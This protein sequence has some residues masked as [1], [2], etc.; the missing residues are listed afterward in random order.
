M[1]ECFSSPFLCFSE[2]QSIIKMNMRGLEGED[3]KRGLKELITSWEP[4]IKD[5]ESFEQAEE[6]LLHL[7]ENDENFHRHEFVKALKRK[8]D[9]TLSPL[10]NEEPERN[11]IAGHAD[12]HES[13]VNNIIDHILQ[14]REYMDLKS[15]LGKNVSEAVKN[16]VSNFNDEF[17]I[18]TGIDTEGPLKTPMSTDDEEGSVMLFNQD[19]LK[20]IAEN[21]SK[22][23][24][25]VTRR[26]Y[27][28]KL[29]QIISGEIVHNKHWQ[30]LRKNLL[31]VMADPDD[32]LS[33]LSLKFV[34]KSFTHTS[35]YTS[36]VFI[37]LIE[38]LCGQFRSMTM[39]PVNKG[40]DCSNK[41]MIKLIKG[42]RLMVEF[43]QEAPNY[44]VRY[45]LTYLEEIVHNSL[46]LLSLQIPA[47]SQNVKL[48]PLHFVAILD[49]GAQWFTKWMHANYC[50]RK[51]LEELKQY[52]AIVETSVRYCLDYSSSHRSPNDEVAQ[53]S[54]DLLK[55]SMTGNGKRLYYT[56]PELEYALFVHSLS[57]LGSLL[58]YEKGRSF[59]PIKLKDKQV[60]M[61]HLLKSLLGLVVDPEMVSADRKTGKVKFE[62]SSLV[63]EVLKSLCITEAMCSI[64]LC[65]DEMM[66][67]LLSPIVAFLEASPD[68]PVPSEKT[69]LHIADILCAVAST[70]IGR[71]FLL[72]G[73]GKSLLAKSKSSAAH[74]IADFTKRSLSNNL[75]KLLAPPSYLV[76]GAYLYV[77]RQL[78]NTPEGLYVLSQYELHSCIAQAWKQLQRE[79]SD[80]SLP[81]VKS[82][83][84]SVLDSWKETL[85]DNLLN[86]ASTAKGIVLLHQTG[87][88]NECVR[89]MY[90]R[91]EKKLQV[92]KCEKFGYGVMVTQV[93]A[94]SAGIQALQST[95]Y[96]KALLM[97]AWS[98]IE[99][100]P[101]DIPAF[102]PKSWPVDPI[103]RNSQKHFIRLVNILSA[104]P[105]VYEL[106]RGEPL[107]A[108]D[109]YS[110][111]D[112]P[113]SIMALI[114]RLIVVD[115]P[116][117]I[118]SLFNYEQ[119][120]TFGLRLLSVMVTCLDTFLLL[121]SQYKFQEF[122]LQEQE[123]NKLEGSDDFITDIL[124]VERNYILVKTY[125][126]G[127][128]TER[129]LP[130]RTLNDKHID[131][132]KPAHAQLPILFSSYPIPKE[133]QPNIQAK[134]STKQDNE[135]SKFLNASRQE[136]KPKVWME[137]CRELFYKLLINKP[138]Q[139]K[140][141]LLLQILEQTVEYQQQL[142]EEAIFPLFD[143]S[144]TDS[145]IKNFKLSPIQVLGVKMTIRYGMHLKV[146]TASS[147]S[148]ENLIQLMKQTGCFLKQQQRSLKSSLRFLEGSYP[149]F[150]WFTATVFLAFN[151]NR[152]KAWNFLYKL[153]SLGTSGYIW[154]VRLHSS[155]L[156]NNLLA[157]GIP[158]LFS[159]TAHNIELLLQSE[160]P[161]VTSAFKMSGYTPSQ[162][163][164][165]WLTQ[166]FWNY[167]DWQ[168]ILHY[169][170]TCVVLGID[171]QVYL[172]VSILRHLQEK[173]LSCM[174]TQELV[175]FLKEEV[176]RDFH[177]IDEIKY[178]KELETKYRRVVL[179][180]MMNISKP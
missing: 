134:S 170:V 102:T 59:F 60:N 122:L 121:Q 85:Q 45:P 50:R 152:E 12:N 80:A 154:I 150:D 90:S 130:S 61:Y 133:Y 109:T 44:W 5:A 20:G 135:L 36:Q 4:I 6:T 146:V 145:T 176:I 41:A 83:K 149:G 92:S 112:I 3:L 129:I 107:P 172:C 125:L 28:Q 180:D 24:N 75:P 151:G 21:L 159:S 117:K 48:F 114:D 86:F 76:I 162:I 111:R 124:S 116:A 179:P 16:L 118:H 42:F 167:L 54:D 157:S 46:N 43:Q 73:E 104:F 88:F 71:R 160:L 2:K 127:G 155:I 141:S 13:R 56:G 68:N 91:Y 177:V 55:L 11:S 82:E 140:G 126:I 66:N 49:P 101:Q 128:P 57:F 100:G 38:F 77:C 148:T 164:L 165:H 1:N 69:L 136:K 25:L 93:A 178:M 142:Q 47:Q 18:R 17:D 99:C 32:E 35:H 144:G 147:E 161:L 52:K 143:F 171:Y 103:D 123:Q 8:L 74:I 97:E 53:V 110:L 27:M 119:S 62:P 22:T 105:A 51:L 63:S 81:V 175:I 79:K 19:Y 39:P 94:T 72:Y 174:Q 84:D 115:S 106:L 158:P 33:D 70:A 137:K 26:E 40:L 138:E 132:D 23:K 108:K 58:F 120:Y 95:G 153:S 9:E 156:P 131:E 96:I 7:E 139:V 169:L 163:C 15:K 89:Y 78:Y 29:N 67:L 14:S 173:I 10:I 31:D 34:G 37:L 65:K 64:A 30:Q 166:C 113:D 168:D 87:E 98:S